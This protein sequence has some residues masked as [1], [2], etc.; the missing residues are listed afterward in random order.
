MR[1]GNKLTNFY[2]AYTESRIQF[3][4]KTCMALQCHKIKLLSIFWLRQFTLQTKESNKIWNLDPFCPLETNLAIFLG[5]FGKQDLI[6]AQTWHGS[7]LLQKTTPRKILWF[8]QLTFETKEINK[9]WNVGSF[10]KLKRN[11]PILGVLIWK[12]GLSFGPNFAWP[13]SVKRRHHCVSFLLK[14]FVFYTK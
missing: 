5:L 7:S 6:L 10:W 2:W 8:S 13:F 14:Q 9:I 3:W 4:P 12:A 11:W 1:T